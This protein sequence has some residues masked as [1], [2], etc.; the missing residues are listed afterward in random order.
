MDDSLSM[1]KK[2]CQNTFFFNNYTTE[3]L[4]TCVNY[5]QQ[6]QYSQN[7]SS[8]DWNRVRMLFLNGLQNCPV[9]PSLITIKALQQRFRRYC[10]QNDTSSLTYEE[11]QYLQNQIPKFTKN[12]KIDWEKISKLEYFISRKRNKSTLKNSY[13][14]L[15]YKF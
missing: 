15:T 6:E 9:N 1:K 13:N 11:K 8:L 3:V 14:K 12:G 2:T 5:V 4:I 7:N 10:K